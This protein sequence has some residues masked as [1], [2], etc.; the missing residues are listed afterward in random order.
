M[1]KP[2]LENHH[3]RNLHQTLA[4]FGLVLHGDYANKKLITLYDEAITT[5]TTTT[6]ATTADLF[7]LV[8]HGDHANEDLIVLHHKAVVNTVNHVRRPRVH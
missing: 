6:T 5:T 4:V 2:Q 7:G 8:L 3:T 1:N